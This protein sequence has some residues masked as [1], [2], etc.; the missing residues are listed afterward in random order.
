MGGRE[1]CSPVCCAEGLFAGIAWIHQ[2]AHAYNAHAAGELLFREREVI[3][4]D[5]AH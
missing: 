3:D 2:L 1:S 5:I 4:K